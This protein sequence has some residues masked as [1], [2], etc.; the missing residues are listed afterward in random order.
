MD[1]PNDISALRLM[2]MECL[3]KLSE[4]EG[5]IAALKAENA[6]LKAENAELRRR[7]GMNSQN[8]N[9]PPGSDGYKKPKSP[10]LPKAKGKKKG[11]QQGH[12]GKTLEMVSVPDR[13]V[14]HH[15]SNCSCCGRVFAAAEP[16]SDLGVRRQVFDIP[17]P[18]ILVTEHRLTGIACCG[19]LHRGSFPGEVAAPVQYGNRACTLVSMLNVDFR[20][21]YG[22]TAQL[23]EDLYGVPMN[24]A[25]VLLANQRLYG[26]LAQVEE[27]IRTALQN[28]D[29]AHFDETGMRV[30]G[31][32]HWFHT[33]CNASYSYL[34]VHGKRGGEA[35]K[36]GCSVLTGFRG[37]AVHDCWKPYFA[38]RQAKH[39]LCNAHLLR[40]LKGLVENGSKWAKKM[41]KFLLGLYE[42]SQQGR[43]VVEN[44]APWAARYR[45]ICLQADREEPPPEK[46]KRGKPKN[47]RGRNLL[48]RLEKHQAAVLAFAVEEI[49]PF[50][51]NPAEQ[52]IRCIK[53][54]QK[55]AMCFRTLEGAQSYARIQSAVKTFR[56][57]G[58]NVFSTLLSANLN[59]EVSLA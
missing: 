32:T 30:A 42:A 22:K 7:L 31:K 34:F 51:N 2:V 43:S 15:P 37:W 1:I 53:V 54:K 24:E 20:L 23:M 13:T 21:S 49:V 28:A 8:S 57:Q 29:I 17:E 25:T 3:A 26:N 33:A 46:G 18:K 5:L 47:S 52:D 40:E 45:A 6:V 58:L 14:L 59:Q 4:H 11:G 27:A 38:F 55:V 50:T 12:A 41:R 44:M 39:A 36:A 56:K 35:L 9:R 16:F 10:A 19:R 48:N